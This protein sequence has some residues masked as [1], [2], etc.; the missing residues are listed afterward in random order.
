MRIVIRRPYSINSD[1][2]IVDGNNKIVLPLCWKN[3]YN[4]VQYQIAIGKYICKL[5][6]EDIVK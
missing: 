4:H 5:I 6:N 1:P 2:A 3:E